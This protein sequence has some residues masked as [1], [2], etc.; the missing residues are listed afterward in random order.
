M[1]EK[2]AL[3]TLQSRDSDE[4]DGLPRDLFETKTGKESCKSEF[5]V[6]RFGVWGC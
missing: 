1:A 4:G 3:L 2:Q 6:A 5:A